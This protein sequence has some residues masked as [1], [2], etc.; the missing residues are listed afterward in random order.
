MTKTVEVTVYELRWP[1]T[2][3]VYVGSTTLKLSKRLRDHR[4]RPRACCAHLDMTKAQIVAV[5]TYTTSDRFNR[6]PEA[7]HKALLRK[8]NRRLLVDDNDNHNQPLW[9][10]AQT[11]AKM[12]AAQTGK[13]HTEDHRAKI[14]EA[15]T[16]AKNHQYAPFTVTWP[17]GRVDQWETTYEAAAHYCVSYRTVWNYLNSKSAP[18][19]HERTAHLKGTIWHYV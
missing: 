1:G 10:T 19:N 11:K 15:Q 5:C 13:T 8:A 9:H 6:Q 3:E 12:S 4:C 16:G 18:G 7:D 14:S 17:D 2:D